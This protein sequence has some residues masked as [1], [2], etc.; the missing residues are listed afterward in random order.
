MF[1]LQQAML[2]NYNFL[3][4]KNDLLILLILLPISLLFAVVTPNI[5]AFLVYGKYPTELIPLFNGIPLVVI[6][7]SII[8]FPILNAF[9]EEIIYNGYCFTKIEEKSNK[10]LAVILVLIFFTLQHIFI[11]FI[12]DLKYLS[13]RLPAFILHSDSIILDISLYKN[14]TAYVINNSSLVNR[15]S[16]SNINIIIKLY[17]I[18]K[19]SVGISNNN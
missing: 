10:I 7:I 9:T 13:W 3:K 12:P 15:Y 19:K 6:I 18:V 11:P 5:V 8:L 2:I 16:S 1:L 17:I 14:E 4:I